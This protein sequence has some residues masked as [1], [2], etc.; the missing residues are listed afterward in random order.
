MND[1]L[2]SFWSSY[3]ALANWLPVEIYT[4]LIRANYALILP[5][6]IAYAGFIRGWRNQAI[7]VLLIVIGALIGLSLPISD[8]LAYNANL[9]PWLIPISLVGLFYMP[10]FL[11]FFIDPNLAA[12][13][14]L[15]GRIQKGILILFLLNL[16][17]SCTE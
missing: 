11:A 6:V 17:V 8:Y 16:L 7:R 1:I 15:R 13:H 3:V 12:Q 4:F 14:R 10:A 9:R 2:T 5:T